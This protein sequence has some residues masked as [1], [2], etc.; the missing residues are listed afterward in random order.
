[1]RSFK[2]NKLITLKLENDG[3]TVIYINNEKFKQCKFILLEIPLENTKRYS[4][5]NSIDDISDR[6]EK[7][8]AN[9]EK[10]QNIPYEVIFWAHC[11][12]I[13]VWCENSYDTRLLHRNLAFP[14]LRKLAN[15]G[16]TIAKIALKEEIIKRVESGQLNIFTYLKSEK[17]LNILEFDELKLLFLE[18]NLRLKDAITKALNNPVKTVQ[19]AFPILNFLTT[20][21]DKI[22]K[23]LLI[24]NIKKWLKDG[25]SKVV[26]N[27]ISS[28]LLDNYIPMN[29]ILDYI[30]IESDKRAIQNLQQTIY[31]KVG[32][33]C[34]EYGRN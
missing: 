5:I 20:K 3:K 7:Y 1:M 26:N 11:S 24:K 16:D 13:Q 9:D 14:L 28:R 32:D 8:L 4:E 19:F 30:V 25:N 2:I 10:S 29:R 18:T 12:N 23:K 33:Y 27:I 17:Y 22:A 6:S 15:L 34:I 21:G 31:N